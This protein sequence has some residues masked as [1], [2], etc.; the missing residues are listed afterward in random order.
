MPPFY[1]K[2]EIFD[3]VLIRQLTLTCDFEQILLLSIAHRRRAAFSVL[4]LIHF[5]DNK[6]FLIQFALFLTVFVIF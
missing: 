1:E 2:L 4:N 3:K 6:T 5:C